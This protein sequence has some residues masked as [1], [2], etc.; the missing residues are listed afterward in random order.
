MNIINAAYGAYKPH[1]PAILGRSSESPPPPRMSGKEWSDASWKY[2]PYTGEH[3]S[4][5]YGPGWDPSSPLFVSPY[6]FF[7]RYCSCLFHHFHS[8]EVSDTPHF[9]LQ[10]PLA[11]KFI[12]ASPAT[13]FSPSRRY[14]EPG[15]LQTACMTLSLSCSSTSFSKAS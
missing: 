4:V 11:Q 7:C 12:M 9:W 15:T 8:A 10:P 5:I 13:A 6:E 2:Q 1:T 3:C 14:G